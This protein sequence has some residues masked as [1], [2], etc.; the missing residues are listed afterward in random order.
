[1]EK[2][3]ELDPFS[4]IIDTDSDVHIFIQNNTTGRWS[5]SR[6]RWKWNPTS[7]TLCSRCAEAYDRIGRYKEALSSIKARIN[8]SLGKKT[9]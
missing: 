1:M 5:T 4:I 2:A 6:K 7:H 8:I 9:P 3:R